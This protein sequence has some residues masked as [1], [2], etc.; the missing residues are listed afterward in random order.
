M[1]I[2]KKKDWLLPSSILL[3]AILVSL[4]LVYSAGKTP[5]TGEQ[6][7]EVPTPTGQEPAEV[8]TPVSADDHIRGASNP[9]VVIVE[10]SDLECP[11]CKSFHDTMTQVIRE[12]D[13]EVAWVYRQF[14]IE[15]LHPKAVKEAEASECAAI[16]GGNEAFWAYVDKIFEVTPSNN[17]LDLALLPDIAEDIGLDRAKF[18]SCLDG[19][20]ASA[21]VGKDMEDVSRLDAWSRQNLGRGVGTPYSVM[22]NLE[23]G[24]S[25]IIPG[26]LP[27]AQVASFVDQILEQ[28]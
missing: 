11:F 22:I 1:E 13:N 24:K 9:K 5:S 18:Q 21:E 2:E 12:Y 10:Y 7:A 27:F 15:T 23:T 17:G 26:A 6:K 19:G 28:K 25:N 14:P 8:I 20:E 16:L 3:A 4:S